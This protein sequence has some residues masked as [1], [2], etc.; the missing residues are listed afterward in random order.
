[1]TQ[2]IKDPEE[3]YQMV[4]CYKKTRTQNLANLFLE[5]KADN[6]DLKFCS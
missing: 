3:L 4:L 1:M 2:C 6:N 5:K